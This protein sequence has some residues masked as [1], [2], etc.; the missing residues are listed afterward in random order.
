VRDGQGVGAAD[1]A[2]AT[3]I[4]DTVT[5]ALSDAVWRPACIVCCQEAKQ[6]HAA[7]E[8]A[9]QI[10]QRAAE[11]VPDVPQIG[12]SQAFTIDPERGPVCWQHVEAAKPDPM[13]LNER[14]Q[15]LGLPPVGLKEADI[16]AA[17]LLARGE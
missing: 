12:I 13:T 16:P 4:L 8:T 17:I 1:R 2:A 5:A 7:H 6:V 9:V 3:A 15:R 10:A 11:P 14:R